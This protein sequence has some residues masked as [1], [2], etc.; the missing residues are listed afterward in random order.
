MEAVKVGGSLRKNLKK[1]KDSQ[2]D[3]VG[4]WT[5]SDGTQYWLSAWRNHDEK[6]GNVWF[7]LKRGNPVEDMPSKP[8]K[9]ASVH[10]IAKGNGY[11]PQNDDDIPF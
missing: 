7:A 9:S 2:P 4:K 10:S 1:E 11:Q 3:L 6:T 8:Q 5:D